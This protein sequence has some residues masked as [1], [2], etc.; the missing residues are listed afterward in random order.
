MP[1]ADNE[2]WKHAEKYAD[3]CKDPF[4]FWAVVKC[5]LQGATW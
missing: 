1:E 3:T 5:A 2:V 4:S